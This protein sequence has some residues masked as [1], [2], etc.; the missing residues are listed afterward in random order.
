[1]HVIRTFQ[2]SLLNNQRWPRKVLTCSK[3]KKEAL[4]WV[5][6][7]QSLDPLSHPLVAFV[8]E[9][10][11]KVAVNLLSCDLLAGGQCDIV[12]VWNLK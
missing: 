8:D 11:S 10:L 2:R 3:G 1:M 7:Q 4:V 12:E 9:L 6:L 5:L